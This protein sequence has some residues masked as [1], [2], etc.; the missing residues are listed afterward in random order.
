MLKAAEI[1]RGVQG[2]N[3]VGEVG[4]EVHRVK[5]RRGTRVALDRDHEE[6]GHADQ[7]DRQHDEGDKHLDQREAAACSGSEGIGEGSSTHG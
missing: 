1:A 7:A 6:L 5:P 3:P 2:A 4:A